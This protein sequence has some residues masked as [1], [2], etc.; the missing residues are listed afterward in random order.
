MPSILYGF[1]IAY[2]F[3]SPLVMS[4]DKN[5]SLQCPALKLE[6]LKNLSQH[7]DLKIGDHKWYLTDSYRI[8]HNALGTDRPSLLTPEDINNAHNIEF[9]KSIG[10]RQCLYQIKIP[11]K[12][13]TGFLLFSLMGEPHSSQG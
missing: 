6:D 12:N 13:F 5:P 4:S 3:S 1:L 9:S 11:S 2:F 10:H 8:T 7:K